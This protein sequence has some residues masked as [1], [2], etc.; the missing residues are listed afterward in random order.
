[1]RATHS[2]KRFYSPVREGIYPNS[3]IAYGKRP[4]EQIK[5]KAKSEGL[6]NFFL[7]DSETGEGLSNLDYAFIAAELGKYPLGSESMNC[8]AP[9]A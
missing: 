6:W 5:G 8:S 1:M 3:V 2:F 7:P 9:K 4:F